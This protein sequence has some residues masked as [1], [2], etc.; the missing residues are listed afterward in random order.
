MSAGQKGEATPDFQEGLADTGVY[1]IEVQIGCRWSQIE[2]LPSTSS[3]KYL[4]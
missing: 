2:S 4:E 3:Q 1:S